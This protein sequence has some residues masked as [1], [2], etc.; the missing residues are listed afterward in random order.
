[1]GIPGGPTALLS[2]RHAWP[3]P[4][5]QSTR[6]VGLSCSQLSE[7]CCGEV[8]D[9]RLVLLTHLGLEAHRAH[10]GRLALAWFG[11][12]FGFGFGLGLGLGLGL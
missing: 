12:G 1:M 10:H 7:A 5:A 6:V 8:A 4:N 11:F 3:G 9:V 2:R